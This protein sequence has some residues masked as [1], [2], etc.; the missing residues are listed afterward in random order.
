[1]IRTALIAF[2][3]SSATV[4]LA[5][6]APWY[7][8]LLAVPATLVVTFA[9]EVAFEIAYRRRIDARMLFKGVCPECSTYNSLDEVTSADPDTRCVG[10]NACGQRYEM[11][12]TENGVLAN[13]L[14]KN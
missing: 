9:G 7:A 10:C 14:G 12:Q 2:A 13:R 1:M 8:I 6:S 5:D 11:Y 3:A 4:F